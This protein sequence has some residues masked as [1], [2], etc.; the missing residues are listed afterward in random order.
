MTPGTLYGVGLGPGDPELITVKGL[1]L[2]Q[3]V[4]RVFVAA[5]A[6]DRSYALQI[7]APYL[8]AARQEIV[9]L[10]CPPY[11]DR[12]A[13]LARWA[14]LAGEVAAAQSDGRD[15]VFL[16]EGDPSLYST[17]LYLKSALASR[18]PTVPVETVPGVTSATAAAAAAGVPLALWDERVAIVPGTAAREHVRAALAQFETVVLLKPGHTAGLI[19]A[20][21]RVA[22]VRRAGRPEQAIL[23]GQAALDEADRDYFSLLIVRKMRA[24]ENEP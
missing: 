4:E 7:A 10:V 11:H 14:E 16:T 23:H 15:A 21:R 18:R 8:D 1:R 22:L 12:A 5:T 3:R 24:E 2:L 17:F 20:G 19:S 6:P 9:R 13:L